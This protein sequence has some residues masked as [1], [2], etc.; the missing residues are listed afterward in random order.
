MDPLARVERAVESAIASIET[1]G[2]APSLAAAMRY[3]A[4][5]GGAR[6]RPKLCLAVA[7]ACGEDAAE[8]TDAAAVSIELLHC[9]SLVHDDLPCFDDAEMRRGRPS[10]HRAFGEPLAVLTGDAMIV[11][12]FELL[13]RAG[14]KHPLRMADLTMLVARSV[15]APSGIVA[16][17]AWECEQTLD[18]TQ[19]H[20]E[21]TGSLFVAATMAGAVSAGADGEAW[22]LLGERIGEAFQVADDIKDVLGSQDDLGKPVGKDAALGR[23]NAANAYGVDAAVDRLE[24][25]LARA[26][27]AIPDCPGADLLRKIVRKEA[28]SFVPKKLL[29]VAA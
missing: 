18:L 14:R 4:I 24:T 17:Q 6:I 19:Y 11:L 1:P 2:C 3:A 12:A 25:L 27:D 13:A 23:P 8:L 29:R 22:R 7:M 9:A 10:V 5:P 26:Q 28:S 16:G 15:G 20:R 21:K